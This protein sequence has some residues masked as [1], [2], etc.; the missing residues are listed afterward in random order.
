M[1]EQTQSSRILIVDDQRVNI[2]LLE[3]I[4]RNAG[5][6]DLV[7]T[8]D[9]SEAASLFR[10]SRPDL[11]MLDL[12]MPEISG[13]E[14]MEQLRVLTMRD[15]YLPIVVLTADVTPETKRAALKA[16]AMDFL[17]KP[18]DS[19]EVILR[20]GNLLETRSL[21]H[22]LEHHA[23]FLAEKLSAKHQ[24]LES[25]H[26]ELVRRLS[27][28]AKYRDDSCEQ[29][30]RRVADHSA[31]LGS[32]HGMDP[33]QIELLRMAAPLHDLGKI[34]ISDSILQKP[35]KLTQEELEQVRKHVHIGAELMRGLDHPVFQ[36]A[37]TIALYHHEW[38]NGAGYFGLKG[39]EIPLEARIVA[40]TD[41]FDVMTHDRPY[42][43]A[44]PV[45]EAVAELRSH[46]GTQFDPHVV[47]LLVA[48]LP[49]LKA[50]AAT[51]IAS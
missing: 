26:V 37:V 14:V 22:R 39:A 38:W 51:A 5:Y 9:P 31:L 18:F 40:V 27:L 12:H 34:A 47:D 23:R 24:E 19:I 42:R 10:N 13:F 45:E 46:S 7:S 35:S 1:R 36:V 49:K 28:A 20:V 15:E 4:L 16:G 6:R 50:V 32:L 21:H 11:V 41:A 30:A 44:W 3:G 43:R 25:S 17:T 33:Y 8:T 2:A 29:H 48:S